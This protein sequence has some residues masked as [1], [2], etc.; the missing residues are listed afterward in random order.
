MQHDKN[1]RK[2]T[3]VLRQRLPS[4]AQLSSVAQTRLS[5]LSQANL[6]DLVRPRVTLCLAT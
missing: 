6:D 1:E 4:A 3:T 5:L 2:E